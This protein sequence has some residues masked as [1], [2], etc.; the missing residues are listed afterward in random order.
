MQAQWRFL[1]VNVGASRRWVVSTKLWLL[2]PPAKS[3]THYA[4]VWV[5]LTAGL[6]GM[7]N[8]AST[9]IWPPD[10]PV[11]SKFLCQVHCPC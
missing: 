10:C 9:T 4:G 3:N 5:H 11:C 6:E 8:L 7:E 1:P 2:Y